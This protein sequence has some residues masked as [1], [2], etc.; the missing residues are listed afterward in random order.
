VTHFRVPKIGLHI[1]IL[2]AF[3]LWALF[4]VLL[5]VST[6]ELQITLRSERRGTRAG[7]T[8]NLAKLEFFDRNPDTALTVPADAV[9]SMIIVKQEGDPGGEN[10]H[11]VWPGNLIAPAALSVYHSGPYI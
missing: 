2:L 9:A 3:F 10:L 6:H 4:G 8:G 11:A 1:K 7:S 5:S